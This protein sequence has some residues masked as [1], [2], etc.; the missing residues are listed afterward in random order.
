[1]AAQPMPTERWTWSASAHPRV[2][3]VVSKRSTSFKWCG[4]LETSAEDAVVGK[5]LCVCAA[6]AVARAVSAA[7][8]VVRPLGVVAMSDE[9]SVPEQLR[10][11]ADLV[12]ATFRKQ[13][14]REL[15]PA[16][17]PCSSIRSRSSDVP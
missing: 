14:S 10:A 7:D 2:E 3:S 5:V 12:V 11:N 8:P 6:A 17:Q 13:L 9:L 4:Q 1:M 16:M 15:A